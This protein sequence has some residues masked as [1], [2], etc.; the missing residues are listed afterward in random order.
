MARY[1]TIRA[2]SAAPFT[3]TIPTMGS[4]REYP[5]LPRV[6]VGGIVIRD[7]RALLIRRGTEPLKGEWSIPGGMLD[8]GETLAEGVIREL[9]EETGLRVKVVELIE[10]FERIFHADEKSAAVLT[11]PEE[12]VQSDGKKPRP[13][14]HFVIIDYYCEAET[15]DPRPGSDVTDVAF[16]T[17]DELA[18]FSLTP[19]ATRV[20]KKAFAI[21]RERAAK[22]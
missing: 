10:V 4:K 11:A 20:I 21:A 15:G 6:G 13:L 3:T 7:G 17:E 19:T 1:V 14:Y 9:W 2:A 16:A 8:I 12:K 18:R 5:D 22:R